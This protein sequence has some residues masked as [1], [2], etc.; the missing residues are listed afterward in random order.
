MDFEI[1][2]LSLQFFRHCTLN[3]W[4]SISKFP[5]LP[6]LHEFSNVLSIKFFLFHIMWLLI[7]NLKYM[8]EIEL[9]PDNS[10]RTIEHQQAKNLLFYKLVFQCTCKF[11]YCNSFYLVYQ[12]WWQLSPE[13][14]A[15]W[16]W[17]SL[18]S[19]SFLNSFENLGSDYVRRC[20]S[21]PSLIWLRGFGE[22]RVHFISTLS[23]IIVKSTGSEI[24]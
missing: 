1:N 4:L 24:S 16:Y 12:S 18:N 9:Q 20:Y 23:W 8:Y 13:R 11:L 3:Q 5:A 22:S 21:L 19:V 17:G 6:T 15:F 7:D 10:P 14:M 2:D